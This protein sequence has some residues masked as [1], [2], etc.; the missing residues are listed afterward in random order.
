[1]APYDERVDVHECDCCVLS[2]LILF[3]ITACL[4]VTQMRLNF[5]TRGFNPSVFYWETVVSVRKILCLI[6]VV[7]AGT[8]FLTAILMAMVTALFTALHNYVKPF[9]LEALNNM[10][11]LSLISIFLCA[12]SFAMVNGPKGSQTSA[13]LTAGQIIFAFTNALMFFVYGTVAFFVMKAARQA[14]KAEKT[15][16]SST[17]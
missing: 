14:R 15:T 12:S 3:E 4:A 1:M 5:F 9:R 7:F 8:D 10:E 13:V 17:A 6:I 2:T 16:S 11:A